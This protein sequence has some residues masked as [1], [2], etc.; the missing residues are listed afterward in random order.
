M[1]TTFAAILFALVGTTLL[2]VPFANAEE[3]VPGQWITLFDGQSLDAW[4]EYNRDSVTTGWKIDDDALTCISRADQGD[5]ARGENIITKEKFD[6]F[7]LELEF[8]VTEAANSGIMFHVLETSK[9]PYF[10]GPEIQIQDH[11]GGHDPQ[12]CGWLY[13]LYPAEVDATKPVGQWNQLRL[14]IAPEKSQ[15]FVNGVLYS[16]FVKGSEDWNK[17]VAASKFGKWQGFGE[18]TSGHICL[19]DHNDEVSY[20]NIRI[21]RL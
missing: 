5:K 18:A 14:V 15:I 3:S 17:R 13:Q 4:R 8:K 10:T 6:A 1:K 21:R 11:K 16:E 2:H 20:R 12:K 19:Q 7:E 9:P